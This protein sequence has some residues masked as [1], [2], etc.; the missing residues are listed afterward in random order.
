MISPAILEFMALQTWKRSRGFEQGELYIPETFLK[1]QPR[2]T[3][4]TGMKRRRNNPSFSF[5]AL[6][7]LQVVNLSDRVEIKN[8]SFAD[9]L[10]ELI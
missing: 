8:A 2:G 6:P 7:A 1:N 10:L 5:P 4:I 9:R 3:G